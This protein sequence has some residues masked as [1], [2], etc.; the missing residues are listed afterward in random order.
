M[1]ITTLKV[2]QNYVARSRGT[3]EWR[4][5]FHHLGEFE[6]PAEAK[7]AGQK[8]QEILPKAQLCLEFMSGHRIP[9]DFNREVLE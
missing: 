4:T 2:G 8:I 1:S 3:F 5:R 6:S 9:L 7:A